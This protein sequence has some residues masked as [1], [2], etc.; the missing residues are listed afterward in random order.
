MRSSRMRS[1]W[2]WPAAALLA[3]VAAVH[4][5]LVPEH[6]REAPYAAGLFI[7]LSAASLVVA[8]LMLYRDEPPVW[9]AAGGLAAGAIVAYVLSRSVGLPMMS[10]DIGDWLNPLGVGAVCA[11][12]II[13]ALSWLILRTTAATQPTG[14]PRPSPLATGRA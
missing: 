14:A 5:A 9:T 7:A 8:A 2:R 4:I 1:D 6:L 11:E 13:V 3:E 10:D 12:A